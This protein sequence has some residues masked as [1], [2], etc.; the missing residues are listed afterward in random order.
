MRQQVWARAALVMGVFLTIYGGKAVLA[1]APFVDTFEDLNHQDGNPV[2]WSRYPAPFD[3]G[4]VQ[5]I[6]GDL[7]ITP[8]NTLIPGFVQYYETDVVVEDRL[9]HDVDIH[10]IARAQSSSLSVFGVGALDTFFTSGT[11]GIGLSGYIRSDLKELGMNMI[12]DDVTTNLGLKTLSFDQ[13]QG[14]VHLRLR[15]QGAKATVTAWLDGTVEPA[16]QISVTLPSSLQNVEG[17]VGIF[18]GSSTTK[19]ATA[20][21]SVAVVPEPS[22]SL[23]V[24]AFLLLPAW[25]RRLPDRKL[26][27][28]REQ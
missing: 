25:R 24:G 2:T 11:S 10:A 4:T 8:G 6:N 21:R 28:G 19:V 3:D 9:Y 12:T 13:Y 17:R 18:A 23:V 22:S 5:S 1:G 7:V 15:V 14:D 26:L 20:F 16:P 27:T